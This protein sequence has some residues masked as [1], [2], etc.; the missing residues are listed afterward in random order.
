MIKPHTN[1]LKDIFL[2]E[3][4]SVFTLL[5]VS[6]KTLRNTSIIKN[7]EHIFSFICFQIVVLRC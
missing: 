5:T 1:I 2:T 3:L 6:D 7:Q 4:S